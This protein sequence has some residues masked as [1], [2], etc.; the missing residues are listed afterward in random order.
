MV[1]V[2]LYS[3]VLKRSGEGG[4]ASGGTTRERWS[5]RRVTS[6]RAHGGD[7]H[8]DHRLVWCVFVF[9]CENWL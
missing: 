5:P 2:R 7:T 9:A 6:M 4:I 3:K 1:H 8:E